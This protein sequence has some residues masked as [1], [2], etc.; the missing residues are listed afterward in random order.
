MMAKMSRNCREC[1]VMRCSGRDVLFLLIYNFF[2]IHYYARSV[3]I[4]SGAGGCLFR[5]ELVV[6]VNTVKMQV[7]RIYR[8]LAVSSRREARHVARQVALV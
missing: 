1:V 7:Q 2:R 6:S 5:N 8:K 3:I 4:P